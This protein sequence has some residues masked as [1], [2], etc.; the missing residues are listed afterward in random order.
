MS[1]TLGWMVI[2]SGRNGVA[3]FEDENPGRLEALD[4]PEGPWT[5]EDG[6]AWA[7]GCDFLRADV[8]AFP[9][10]VCLESHKKMEAFMDAMDR[11]CE[12]LNKGRTWVMVKR[13]WFWSAVMPVLGGRHDNPFE[14]TRFEVFCAIKSKVGKSGMQFVTWREMECRS[15]GYVNQADMERGLPLRKDGAK[16]MSRDKIRTRADYVRDKNLMVSYTPSAT[17]A[18]G[19]Q[20]W[21]PVAYGYG[22]TEKQLIAWADE[23]MSKKAGGCKA[24]RRTKREAQQK[25]S[26]Q[27]RPELKG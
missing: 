25:L 8:N 7:L 21:K 23:Q 3:K 19:N 17:A 12:R 22:V 5:Y 10:N 18:N 2:E 13:E 9:P 26:Q 15:M 16:P 4:E 20:A 1:T 11:H 6:Q 27:M 24:K 14:W